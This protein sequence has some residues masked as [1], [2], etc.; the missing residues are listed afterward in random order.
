MCVFNLCEFYNL[1][2]GS[3]VG[4]VV[5][6]LLVIFYE[7]ILVDGRKRKKLEKHFKPLES[8]DQ[9]TFDWTCFDIE[10]REKAKPNGSMA[11]IKYLGENTLEI[12]VKESDESI[13]VG[14][15]TMTDLARGSL[16]FSYPGKY[17]YGFKKCYLGQEYDQSEG[18]RFDYLILVG[19]GKTYLNELVRRERK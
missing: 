16:T 7:K 12:E 15:I 6:L 17:E 11:K 19:D 4:G 13:W 18:K 2:I 9:N 10:G 14:Y 1:I 3:I 5:G 8:N